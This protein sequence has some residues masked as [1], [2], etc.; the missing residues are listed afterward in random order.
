MKLV[1]IKPNEFNELAQSEPNISFYQTT[2]WG[3]FYKNIG[4]QPLYIGYVDE[5]NIYCALALILIKNKESFFSRKTALC[6]YGY[7]INYYDTELLKN[8]TLDLKKFLS[9][10]GI[11]QITINPN[12]AYLTSRG[13]NEL[14]IKNISNIGYKKTKNNSL[15]VTKIENIPEVKIDEDVYLETYVIE[16][17]NQEAK[18]FK[19]NHNY[20]NLYD[21]MRR[22]V[23]FVVC[24]LDTNRSINELNNKLNNA[25]TYIELHKEEINND[26]LDS[27]RKLVAEKQP[28]LDLLNK[29]A[30][31]NTESNLLA[32]TCFVEFNNK[33]TILFTDSKKDY[34]VLN[35]VDLLNSK[36]LETLSKL[37]YESFESYIETKTSQKIDLIGEFTYQ[38]K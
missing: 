18:L 35:A 14:L 16:N 34:S 31:D 19:E 38:V 7:L 36:T 10:K 3:E 27:N 28:L 8:F 5:H 37:G 20:K 17:N 22:Y 1:E 32:V 25:K 23:K 9:K 4:Y 2:N 6:Q 11:G 15:F 12:V 33:A 26:V 21:A 13:N 30:H 24:E 29:Y